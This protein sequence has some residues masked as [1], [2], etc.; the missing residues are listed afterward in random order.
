MVRKGASPV[1]K[2][3]A[4]ERRDR[5][6]GLLASLPVDAKPTQQQLADA[7][8]DDVDQSTI[9]RDIAILR[10]R[11]QESAK[12]KTD[13][14]IG[15]QLARYESLIASHWPLATSG[16]TRNAEIVM[17]AMAGEAK[18]LGLDQPAKQQ[19]EMDVTRFRV[20]GVSDDELAGVI[21]PGGQG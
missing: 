7:L 21:T 6:A 2:A 4:D 20:I 19:I 11:W 8:G 16:K 5:L 9:S 18:L 17:Q 1:D 3:V 13:H 10:R 15:L 14:L 12:E